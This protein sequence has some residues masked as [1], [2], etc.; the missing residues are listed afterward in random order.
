MDRNQHSLNPF[1]TQ[2]QANVGPREKRTAEVLA[3]QQEKVEKI[4]TAIVPKIGDVEIADS[5]CIWKP[6]TSLK[7]AIF[8]TKFERDIER[9][10]NPKL[11]AHT[12]L[13][14]LTNQYNTLGD[15]R[16]VI[17]FLSKS[18]SLSELGHN[19]GL[20]RD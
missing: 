16:Y 12:E 19:L 3:E 17:E 20:R 7:D 9:R 18:N 11:S 15:I 14:L 6:V 2:L 10:K 5:D 1:Q 13:L 4:P 8:T